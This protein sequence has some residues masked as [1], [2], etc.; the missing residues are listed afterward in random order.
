MRQE[1]NSDGAS[2]REEVTGPGRLITKNQPEMGCHT[3]F[4]VTLNYRKAS[5]LGLAWL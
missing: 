3:E 5:K 2:L 1:K 4:C